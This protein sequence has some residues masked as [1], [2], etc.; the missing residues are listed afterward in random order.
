MK[1]DTKT[2]PTLRFPE[3]HSDWNNKRFGEIFSF[4][5]TNSFSRENLNYETG[6]VKNIHYGDIHTKFNIL[7][8]ITK[9]KVPYVNNE[10]DLSKITAEHYCKEGDL[11]IADASED[12]A[13]VGKCIEIINLNNEKVLA[14]LHT[15]LARPDLFQMAPGFNGYLMKSPTIRLQ[16]MTIA[17]GTKVYGISAGRLCKIELKIPS[18]AEQQKIAAFLSAVDEKVA[19]LTLKKELLLKYKK[20]VMQQIFGQKIRFKDEKGQDYS[21]WGESPLGM[22]CKIYDG[23]HMTPDYQESGVPFYSVEHVT[24]NDFANTKYIADEIYEQEKKRVVIEKGDILMTRIGDIGTSKYISWDAKASFYVSLALIKQSSK[25]D[26]EYLD[27][28]MKSDLFQRE[29]HRRTLHVAF[30]KKINLGEISDC[31]VRTPVR[32]EQRKIATFLLAIDQRTELANEQLKRMKT[33]KKG[34]LQQMFV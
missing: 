29:L 7:F 10:I 30:P 14:G 25:I 13:D 31:K 2:S 32:E 26:P 3:F 22:L 1:S 6:S 20:G 16:I 17:Q 23:T 19:Q 15:F 24:S 34:L 9:E 11:V 12:Y 27:Q 8:D 18:Q 33:F 5:S 28:F 4:R 21:E